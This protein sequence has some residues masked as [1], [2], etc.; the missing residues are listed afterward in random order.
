MVASFLNLIFRNPDGSWTFV[1]WYFGALALLMTAAGVWCLVA[2]ESYV[3]RMI[4]PRWR[5]SQRWR[6][7]SASE[8]APT[9]AQQ[10]W[11][12]RPGWVRLVSAVAMALGICVITWLLFF[13]VAGRQY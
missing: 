13:S 6:S 2:P 12:A 1:F 8:M 9:P 4:Q 10:F 11:A 5:R 7:G 3:R